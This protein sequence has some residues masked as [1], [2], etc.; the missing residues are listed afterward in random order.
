VTISVDPDDPKAG[1]K[2]ILTC[3]TGSSNPTAKVHWRHK[4][5]ILSGVDTAIRPGKIVNQNLRTISTD[6]LIE[7]F[8]SI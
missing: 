7:S 4:D 2:A 6:Y 1:K 8:F 3:V 5:K